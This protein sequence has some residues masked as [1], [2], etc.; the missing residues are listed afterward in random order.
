MSRYFF[1]VNDGRLISSDRGLELSDDAAARH[2]AEQIASDIARA[3]PDGDELQIIVTNE[4]GL[5]ITQVPTR[6][7]TKD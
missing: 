5:T 2:E 6:Q 3:R 7:K 4:A 1:H